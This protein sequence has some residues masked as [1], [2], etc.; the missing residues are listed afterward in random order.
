MTRSF[1][2]G[3]VLAACAIVGCDGGGPEC[4]ID[5]DCMLGLRCASDGVCRIIG[6]EM[7]SGS[8]T[9]SGPARDAA[10][11]GG[12]DT[13]LADTGPTDAQ[14]LDAAPEDADVDAD[15]DADVDAFTAP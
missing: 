2:L 6:E 10:G 11:E 14:P 9:D 7:D 4:A 8:R 13:G 15:I 5:T 1:F 3:V 12:A